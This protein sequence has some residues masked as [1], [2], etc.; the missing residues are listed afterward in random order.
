MSQRDTTE[1]EK[2]NK[3]RFFLPAMQQEGYAFESNL[4]NPKYH[5]D[6]IESE[7][8]LAVLTRQKAGIA[9]TELPSYLQGALDD[10]IQKQWFERKPLKFVHLRP[11]RTSE[12]EQ[13]NYILVQKER[14]DEQRVD[15]Y[16]NREIARFKRQQ[17]E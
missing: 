8:H 17:R 4:K 10:P 1:K 14:V 15:K 13:R 3:D 7:K 2:I 11:S 16:I 6:I 12:T 5:V 9:G